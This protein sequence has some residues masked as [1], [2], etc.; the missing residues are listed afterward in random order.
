MFGFLRKKKA[1][2]PQK[3]KEKKRMLPLHCALLMYSQPIKA[4]LISH[5][6]PCFMSSKES[7]KEP[8]QKLT[9][10]R[11][12]LQRIIQYHKLQYSQ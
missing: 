8:E 4:A 11:E 7:S 6:K 1:M 9:S 2:K 10:I 3:K 5:L 12:K